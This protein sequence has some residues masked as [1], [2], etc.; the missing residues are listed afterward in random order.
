MKALINN[1]AIFTLAL[2]F[3][4]FTNCQPKLDDSHFKEF[5]KEFEKEYRPLHNAMKLAEF[6][7]AISGTDSDYQKATDLNI[8][9]TELLS[10]KNSFQTLK[11][12]KTANIL[13]DKT[14]KRELQVVYNLYQFH[15]VPKAEMAEMILKSQKIEQNFSHFRA[16]VD[17]VSYGDA[18]IEDKLRNT[19]DS[20]DLERYWKASK[21][22]G[23]LVAKDFIELAKMRNKAAKTLGYNNYF[24]M[25]LLLE[26]QDPKKLENLY[27]E[28]DLITRDPYKEIKAT[29]DERLS[30]IY[31]IPPEQLMPWHYQ[32]RFFQESPNIFDVKLDKYYAGKNIV[33]LSQFYYNGIG[34]NI[35]NVLANSD[36]T[37]KKGKTPAGFSTDLNREGDIR[38]VATM[39]VSEYSMNTMLYES[40]YSA[41]LKNINVDLPYILR[42]PS[43]IFIADAV[44]TLFGRFSANPDWLEEMITIGAKEKEAIEDKCNMHH[45]M[46][47]LVFSRWAQVMYHFEKSLYENPEQNLNKLWWQLVNEYQLL[48]TPGDWD[49][50]DWATKIHIITEPCTYHNYML[51]ELYA[52]QLHN[53]I[54]TQIV[55]DDSDDCAIKCINNP[56]IGAYLISKIFKH[57]KSLSWDEIVQESTN[58]ALN[59]NYYQRQYVNP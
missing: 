37:H 41:Y 53:Y 13:K 14:L 43:H 23:K 56:E 52:S 57:G 28:F 31:S 10:D 5:I 18:E 44:A 49:N 20:H 6:N 4:I 22:V 51:G 12:Y 21:K 3:I 40:A 48:N 45:M 11:E 25:R 54:K 32:N 50:P 42:E 59:P 30:F 34:L 7:A 36:L 33:K 1:T 19:L 35:D 29:I 24:E 46:D 55:K 2:S 47:K 8:Q 58:E 38:I 27:E 16:T 15:Q 9:I 26:D 39:D 17:D